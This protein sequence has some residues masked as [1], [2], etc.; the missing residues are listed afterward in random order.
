MNPSKH[1]SV[2]DNGLTFTGDITG[3][4]QLVI[5][6]AVSGTIK[7][8]SIIIAEEGRAQCDATVRS[9]TVGGIYEGTLIAEKELVVLKGGRCSGTVSCGDLIVEAGGVVN[10]AVTCK[11]TEAAPKSE[12][13]K[14]KGSPLDTPKPSKE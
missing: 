3:K 9:M 6:G 1:L 5:K 8:D 11:K 7:T 13:G 12:T 10:A 14:K 4:G 2:I